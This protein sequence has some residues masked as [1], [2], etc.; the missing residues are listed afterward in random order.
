MPNKLQ[1]GRESYGRREWNEACRLLSLADQET[2]LEVEDLERLATAAYL[3]GRELDFQRFLDRAHQ[4]HLKAG[5]GG[6]AAR[7]AFWLGLSLFLRGQ[8]ALANG[9]LGRAQRLVEERD[10]VER[11]YLL[12]PIA[13]QQLGEGKAGSAETTAARA[14]EIGSRFRDADLI[15]CAR[16]VQGRARIQQRQVQDGLRLLDEAMLA[17]IVGELSPIMTGLIYCSVIEA[18]QQVCA[19]SR[20]REWTAALARW[21]EQQPQIVAFTATCL[22]HRAEI[23]QLSGNWA[24]AMAEA[25]RAGER[26]SHE[27]E[28]DPPAAA[29]YQQAELYRLQGQYGAAEEAYRSAARL[30]RDPQPGLALLRMAQGRTDAACAAIRRV[31]GSTAEPLKR[32]K[33]LPAQIEILLRTGDIPEAR[34]ACRE[35]EHIAATFETDVLRAM[36]AQAQGALTLAEGDVRAALGPLR[37]AFEMWRQVEAPYEAARVRVQIGM[38]CSALGD[39]EAGDLEFRAARA[40]FEQLGATPQIAYLD[41]LSKSGSSG[42]Q[43]LLS[44]RELEVLRLV[45]AGKTNKA[46]AA[47]LCLS[48]RTIDRHVSNILAKLNVPSRAA[49]TAEAYNRKLL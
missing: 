6:P 3:G 11:G 15:A 37:Q 14:A 12:L 1:R 43:C 17:V 38:A 49:A 41:S 9:W 22:V 13:E 25:C 2:P 4:A 44:L 16:H 28:R 5:D 40:V 46:I 33:L 42:R 48:E 20:A 34:G 10:C 23:L 21:C 35:L 36:A 18:C 24:G 31:L 32:A 29:L 39:D 19:M 30:G 47:L 7:C 45:A 26:D 27:V 8:A